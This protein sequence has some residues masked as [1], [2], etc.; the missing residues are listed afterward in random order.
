MRNLRLC[1]VIAP[2]ID[3]AYAQLYLMRNVQSCAV[4]APCINFAYVQL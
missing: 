4:I 1:A 3:F 2:C